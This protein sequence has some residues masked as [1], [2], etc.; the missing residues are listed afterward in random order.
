[1]VAP[2]RSVATF[3]EVSVL[4]DVVV[5]AHPPPG[6]LTT[7]GAWSHHCSTPEDGVP[8]SDSYKYD[9]RRSVK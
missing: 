3:V 8:G 1:M 4:L 7:G 9:A 2:P 5:V 6:G